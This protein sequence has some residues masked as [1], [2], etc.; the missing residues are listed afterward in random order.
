MLWS[1][2]EKYVTKVL[3]RFNMDNVKP[4]GSTLLLKL[5]L[6]CGQCLKSEKDKAKL[7][8]VLYAS[9]VGSLMYT[10][11]CTRPDIVFTIG[12]R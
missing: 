10:M 1:S 8:K 4:V 12:R 6:N 7:E 2:P 5:K 3:Q 9:V 11:V